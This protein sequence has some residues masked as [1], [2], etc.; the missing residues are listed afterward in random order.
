MKKSN[1]K[2]N[3]NCP[4]CRSSILHFEGDQFCVDCDW[5]TMLADVQSGRFERRLGLIQEPQSSVA[6]IAADAIE[7]DHEDTVSASAS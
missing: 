4:V 6:F 1:Q 5:N 7:V 3:D 2:R